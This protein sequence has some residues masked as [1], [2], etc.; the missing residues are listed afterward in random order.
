VSKRGQ[1][2]LDLSADKKR[3]L[4]LT[5]VSRET[6]KRLDAFVARLLQWQA[7]INLIAPSTVAQVWTRHVA[8][9]L[10]LIALASEA[11]VW[12]D[13]G[14]GGGF[15]GIVIACALAETPGAR[16]HLVESNSKKAAFLREAVRVTAVPAEVHQERVENFGESY[17]EPVHAV[18][19]RALA[20]LKTLCDQ[21]FPLIARGAVGL[22]PK[23]QD[24]AAELTQAAKYWSI[25]AEQVPSKTSPQG[26]IVVVRGLRPKE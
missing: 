10:Q 1:G 11:R 13:F 5:P 16:V 4:S 6:E 7:R 23:G 8:D 14:S 18:T 24:V 25:T 22:F 26:C 3:A 9:S 15:P 17:A 19:A 20:P 2:V 21:A 12:V